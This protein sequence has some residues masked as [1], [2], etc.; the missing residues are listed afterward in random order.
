MNIDGR[1]AVITG[2]AGGIGAALAARLVAGGARVAIADLDA[3]R[4]A[5]TAAAL[6][7]ATVAMAGDVAD[8]GFLAD[9][10]AAAGPVD[11]FFANAGVWA[12]PGLEADD[13]AWAQSLDVN[14]MAHVRAARLLV[15]QWLARGE[16]YFVATASAAGLLTQIGSATYSVSKH[17]TVAFAEWLSVTY[18][19][20]G[21]RVSCLCP[22]G[23]NTNLLNDAL[24]SDH[25]DSQRGARTV[26]AAGSVLEPGDVA[27]QVL[28]A[29]AEERFLILP[30]PE[31]QEFFRRRAADHERWLA[32]MRRLQASLG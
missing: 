29:I 18:G 11:L 25:E 19:E 26:A 17:A 9:L 1:V 8:A 31:V 16:G 3:D 13:A 14:V 24:S 20:R 21:V 23:V 7:P 10:L 4:L 30:H 6:G 32:G 5:A 28:A 27:D 12:A 15:P 2:A 22:M